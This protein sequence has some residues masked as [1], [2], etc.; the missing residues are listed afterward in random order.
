MPA[1]D[2]SNSLRFSIGC[3]LSVITLIALTFG[4]CVAFIRYA[5]GED[6]IATFDCGRGRE[7]VISV[8]RSWEVSQPIYYKIWDNGDV[9]VPKTYFDNND[10]PAVPRFILTIAN[11]GDLVGVS[12]ADATKTYLFI[13][14]FSDGE[15]HDA[16]DRPDL[17]SLLDASLSGTS[18]GG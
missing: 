7:I 12:Y 15:T 11:D 2:T 9:V 4:G 3:L 10:P 14:D 17:K 13:H 16:A 6:T 18:A 8:S 1:E 5:D